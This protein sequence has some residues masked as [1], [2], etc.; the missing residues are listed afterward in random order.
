MDGVTFELSGELGHFRNIFTHSFF[1]TLIAPPRTTVIGLIGA[2]LGFDEAQTIELMDKLAVGV[3]ILNIN[4]FTREITTFYN[5]KEK[6]PVATPIMREIIVKP[7]YRIYVLCKE[8][9]L[10]DRIAEALR[11][12]KYTLYLGIS[13]YLA[14]VSSIMRVNFTKT[15]SKKFDTMIEYVDG[16]RARLIDVSAK[17]LIPPKQYR[18]VYS[19]ELTKTG[20]RPTKFADVLMF[21][22]YAVELP[23]ELTAYRIEENGEVVYLL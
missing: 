13:D 19:Y 2:A 15:K 20:R 16:Y 11:H 21:F 14:V 18:I 3:K 22:G 8:G 9:G 12:P 10:S 17:T 23:K 6:P 1:E 4:G 7:R 5:Y